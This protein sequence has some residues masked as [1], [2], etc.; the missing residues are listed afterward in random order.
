MNPKL[1][2]FQEYLSNLLDEY[3]FAASQV[4]RYEYKAGAYGFLH[5]GGYY[6]ASI[7]LHPDRIKYF[8]ETSDYTVSR[9][10]VFIKNRDDIRR[11][12]PGIIE[13]IKKADRV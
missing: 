9:G 2:E 11:E 10:E 1:I 6:D 8:I 4:I 12:L 3:N 7:F 5:V 13:K